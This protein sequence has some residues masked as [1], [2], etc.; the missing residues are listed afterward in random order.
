MRSRGVGSY[1]R[2]T[3]VSGPSAQ[4]SSSAQRVLA[5]VQQE[6]TEYLRAVLRRA[7]PQPSA[8]PIFALA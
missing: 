1:E 8:A 3:R 2:R 7:V 5:T 4:Q 6:F